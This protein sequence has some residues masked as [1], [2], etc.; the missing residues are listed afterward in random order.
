[1]QRTVVFTGTFKIIKD[2]AAIPIYTLYHTRITFH[3]SSR[4]LPLFCILFLPFGS[5]IHND[6]MRLDVFVKES[7]F[8]EFRQSLFSQYAR[9][10]IVYAFIV[11]TIRF[12]ALKWPMWCGEGKECEEWLIVSR[13]LGAGFLRLTCPGSI[14]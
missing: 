5:S 14:S 4:E 3:S 6:I 12:V 8:L 10:F 13:V 2:F 11:V 1:M 9:T 7:Q